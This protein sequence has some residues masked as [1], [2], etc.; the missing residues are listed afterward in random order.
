MQLRNINILRG[1]AAFA[2]MWF[3]LTNNSALSKSVA[4]TGKYGYL[5]VEIFFVISGYILPYSMAKRNYRL[6]NFG[7]FNLKRILRIYPPYLITILLGIGLMLVTNIPIPKKHI[8]LSEF[9]YMNSIWGYV[10]T[11]PV[12]W[13]LAIE[14]QFYIFVSFA[15][16]LISSRSNVVFISSLL[17]FL[18]LA[19][20][21]PGAFLPSWLGMFSLGIILFRKTELRLQNTPFWILIIIISAFIMYIN[22]VYPSIT[23]LL[24]VLFIAFVPVKGN[25]MITRAGLWL[26]SISYS[27]YLIHWD[28]GR[29]MIAVFRHI[30]FVGSFEWLRLLFGLSASL[31]FAW[32][33][34]K[35]I[36][37]PSI[38]LSHKLR[39]N[40]NHTE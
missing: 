13:T 16:P 18:A 40:H 24:T 17:P 23:C 2:V 28:W 21:L 30:P 27:L 31:L 7:T 10:W 1:I 32:L 9:V 22:G 29:V 11:A 33:F 19:F 35:I 36:E 5:G 34:Y 37:S 20:V 14:I 8:L 15:Y 39:Y 26:G 12:F 6:A 38:K 4:N 25:N 3:H